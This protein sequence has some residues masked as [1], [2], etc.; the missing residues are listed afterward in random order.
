MTPRS[1]VGVDLDD[2][3]IGFQHVDHEVRALALQA[4]G[5][6]APLGSM[7]GVRSSLHRLRGIVGIE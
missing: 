6:P 2:A 7:R 3:D 4:D 5:E 1:L